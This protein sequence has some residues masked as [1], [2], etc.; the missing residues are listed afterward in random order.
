M[1]R[2]F[3]KNFF[4]RSFFY[5]AHKMTPIPLP[6]IKKMMCLISSVQHTCLAGID[7]TTDKGSFGTTPLCQKQFT[8]DPM[9]QVE[10]KVQF[11]LVGICSHRPNAWKVLNRSVI[12]LWQ[13]DHQARNIVT[14][15][16]R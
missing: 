10:A 16:F 3:F 4:V 9:I 15:K 6:L 5:A 1:H 2:E 14:A 13:Q 7:D 8:R 12:H 11:C